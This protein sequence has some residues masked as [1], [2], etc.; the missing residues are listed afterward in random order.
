[1]WKKLLALMVIIITAA[2]L[3]GQELQHE[4][5]AINIEVPVR[6]FKGNTF[7][8]DLTTADFEI[9]ED[10]VLQEIKAVY[11]IQKDMIVKRGPKV[12]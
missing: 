3:I 1:M 8:T 12:W 5:V 10:G 4:A 9:Y 6:V 11:L 2:V 7:I